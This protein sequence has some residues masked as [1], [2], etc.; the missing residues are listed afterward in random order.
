MNYA[1]LTDPDAK[2]SEKQWKIIRALFSEMRQDCDWVLTTDK[3]WNVAQ[4]AR[5]YGLRN[6]M[7]CRTMLVGPAD[8]LE[9]PREET[10]RRM[11]W[12]TDVA[13]FFPGNMEANI[14]PRAIPALVVYPDGHCDLLQ[15][16]THV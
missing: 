11:L 14:Q 10:G 7:F 6:W 1:F 3:D 12:E 5:G 16:V 4:V 15:G 13:F 2:L 9:A 8:R